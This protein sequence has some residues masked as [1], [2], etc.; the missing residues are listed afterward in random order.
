MV[1]LAIKCEYK[2]DETSC[3]ELKTMEPKQGDNFAESFVPDFLKN[4][5]KEKSYMI[6]YNIEKSDIP[7][8]CYNENDK[9]ECEQHNSMKES[10]RCWDKKG[11]WLEEE[12]PGPKNKET[13]MQEAIPQ[14]YD[15]NDNFLEEKCG[16]ITMVENEDGMINYIIENELNGI[17]DGLENKSTQN[18]IDVNESLGQTNVLDI[19][20]KIVDVEDDIENWVVD[21]PPMDVDDD[22]LTWDIKTDIRDDDGDDN[23]VVIDNNGDDSG[24]DGDD[25]DV[26][27]DGPGEPGV[28]DED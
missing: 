23:N 6:D 11:N 17:I 1:A 15:E 25:V 26:V 8:E 16:K 7:P 22:G 10:A 18:T 24:D 13:T 5:F 4:L 19:E 3:S 28:V 21:H 12:C 14:C 2:E 20:G 9:P 27:D